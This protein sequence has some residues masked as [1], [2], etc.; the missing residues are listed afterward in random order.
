MRSERTTPEPTP[1]LSPQ[2][3]EP[4]ARLS[5]L[6]LDLG[7]RSPRRFN[8]FRQ[9]VRSALEKGLGRQPA[10]VGLPLRQTSLLAL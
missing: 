9:S 3:S 4:A 6:E 10:P 2:I 7:K 5:A 8:R 1:Q